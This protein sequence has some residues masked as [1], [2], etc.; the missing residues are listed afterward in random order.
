MQTHVANT[1]G[2][3]MTESQKWFSISLIFWLTLVLVAAVLSLLSALT[4]VLL[5]FMVAV[6]IAYIG[7]PLVNRLV[8]LAVPHLL[9]VTL[10][11]LFLFGILLGLILLIVPVVEQQITLLIKNLPEYI[12]KLDTQ[13]I[14]GLFATFGFESSDYTRVGSQLRSLLE[15]KWTEAGQSIAHI[16]GFIG[17]SGAAIINFLLSMVLIPVLSFYFMRDWSSLWGRIRNL[18]PRY[19]EKTVLKLASESNTV[20]SAFLRGQL[21]VMLALGTVYSLGLSLVGLDLAFL[22]GFIAGLISFVPYLGFVVGLLAASIAF[23]MQS[24][25]PINL[26]Y[27]LGVFTVGQ[28]LESFILTPWLLGGKIGL[29]PVAVIF[30]VLAGGQLLGFTGVLIALPVAAVIVVLLRY[31]RDQYLDS[32]YYQDKQTAQADADK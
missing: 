30:A 20:L 18:V 19:Q 23:L 11:F 2:A 21:T 9:A 14:P 17:N 10:V 32:D 7:T 6:V 4:S 29:H 28:L 16:L 8:D 27:V 24:P 22:I 13:I 25:E 26:L 3:V 15:Q 1:Q 5:P 12:Q 31:V